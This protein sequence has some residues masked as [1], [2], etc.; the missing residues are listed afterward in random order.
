MW[1]DDTFSKRNKAAKREKRDQTKFE[2][3]GGKGL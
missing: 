1:R 2:K 3:E